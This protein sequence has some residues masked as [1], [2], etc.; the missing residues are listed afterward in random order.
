M[1]SKKDFRKTLNLMLSIYYE[2]GGPLFIHQEID[3]RKISGITFEE[4]SAGFNTLHKDDYV[5]HVAPGFSSVPCGAIAG[6]GRIFYE[7]G[8]YQDQTTKVD[9]LIKWARNHTIISW[10]IVGFIALSLI[11]CVL[12]TILKLLGL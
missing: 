8:G 12:G 1:V 11:A 5:E 6:K 7:S 4:A 2:H 3:N 10:I 9:K